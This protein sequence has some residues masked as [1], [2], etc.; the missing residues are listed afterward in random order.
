MGLFGIGKGIG[1]IVAG[2]LEGDA[3]KIVK[4]VAQ[5]ALGTVT[6]VVCAASGD[7][8]KIVNN[9][10]DDVLDN[11]HSEMKQFFVQVAKFKLLTN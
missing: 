4:G 8:G 9:E 1:K 6:T 3:G 11:Q 10:T 2:V 5:T 7:G